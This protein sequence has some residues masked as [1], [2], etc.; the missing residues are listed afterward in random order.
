M[1][2]YIGMNIH[3]RV[4][5]GL[6]EMCYRDRELWWTRKR[7]V[8]NIFVEPYCPEQVAR[9]FGCMQVFPLPRLQLDRSHR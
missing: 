5:L 1:D 2:P 7:L 9:Q 4:S 6:L 3:S 8:L